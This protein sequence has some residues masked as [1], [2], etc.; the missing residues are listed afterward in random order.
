MRLQGPPDFTG[1]IGIGGVELT[2]SDGQIDVPDALVEDLKRYHG[3]VE[4]D[5]IDVIATRAIAAAKQDAAKADYAAKA[6]K[7]K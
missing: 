3:F 4:V 6:D 2:A 7:S 5:S 1:K